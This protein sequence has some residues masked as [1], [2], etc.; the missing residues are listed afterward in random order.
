[1]A[2]GTRGFP[3]LVERVPRRFLPPWRKNV[4]CAVPAKSAQSGSVAICR[5]VGWTRQQRQWTHT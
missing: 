1:M 5:T 2:S 4:L 3:F